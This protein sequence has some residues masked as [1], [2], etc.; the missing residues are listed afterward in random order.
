MLDGSVVQIVVGAM[1]V[2]AGQHLLA[3]LF[4]V[5]PRVRDES[6]ISAS[7]INAESATAV[8]RG[9]GIPRRVRDLGAPDRGLGSRSDRGSTA[10]AADATRARG[11][12]SEPVLDRFMPAVEHIERFIGWALVPPGASHMRRLRRRHDE[13]YGMYLEWTVCHHVV[14]LPERTF[15]TLLKRHPQV[16]AKREP[17]INPATGGYVRKPSGVPERETIYTLSPPRAGVLPGKP[18]VADVIP[19]R[20]VMTKSQREKLKAAAT[21][22]GQPL[23]AVAEAQPRRI[24]A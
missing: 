15:Q 19:A 8:R 9:R 22:P 18:P 13:A 16:S 7:K 2:L 21:Q 3:R 20:P 12:A 5:P 6:A 14:P 1:G 24:A 23:P 4:F 11:R 10:V 17:L